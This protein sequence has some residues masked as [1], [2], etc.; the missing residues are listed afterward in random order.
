MYDVEAEVGVSGTTGTGPLL[1]QRN[2]TAWLPFPHSPSLPPPVTQVTPALTARGRLVGRIVL[3]GL[4]A[5]I[6]CNVVIILNRA[7]GHS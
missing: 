2:L 6:C 1:F 5:F 4:S 3:Q 7:F